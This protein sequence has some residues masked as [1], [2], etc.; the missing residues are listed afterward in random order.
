MSDKTE[1][2]GTCKYSRKPH[3]KWSGCEDWTPLPDPAAPPVA[4]Q[5]CVCRGESKHFT[6]HSK[7]C[8]GVIAPVAQP[9]QGERLPEW[10][11][12]VKEFSNGFVAFGHY[13]VASDI[14]KNGA[15]EKLRKLTIRQI[16]GPNHISGLLK[17]IPLKSASPTPEAAATELPKIMMPRSQKVMILGRGP[18]SDHEICLKEDVLVLFE[19]VQAA[20]RELTP[21]REELADERL[22]FQHANEVVGKLEA[23]R[24]ALQAKL[25]ES[26]KKAAKYLE[27]HDRAIDEV[28]ELRAKLDGL[29]REDAAQR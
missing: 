12:E 4:Q 29:A 6:F 15:I 19:S 24:D 2:L 14:T 22:A 26:E 17:E 27:Y 9:A 18:A 20:L 10:C 25:E 13:C 21:L 1:V 11:V 8:C 7:E 23:E 16:D 28:A 5:N 3:D